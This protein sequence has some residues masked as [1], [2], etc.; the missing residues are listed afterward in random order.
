MAEPSLDAPP[1]AAW[2]ATFAAA[3]M[4][5]QQVVGKATRDTLYLSTYSVS[6]LPNMML[7]AAGCSFGAVLLM[8][9]ALARFSPAKVVPA[10]FILSL[11]LFAVEFACVKRFP[12]IVAVVL[13]IHMATLGSTVISGFWSLINERF[14]PHTAKKFVSRI[15]SGGTLGGVFGGLIAWRSASHVSL[16]GILFFL[17]II[18]LL[19]AVLVMVVQKPQ[20]TEVVATAQPNTPSQQLSAIQIL[21]DVRYLRTIA[22]LVAIGA[23]TETLI[24]YLLS[25]DVKANFPERSQM[26]TF[27]SMY[28]TGIGL[29]SFLL[30]SLLSRATLSFLGLAGTVAL[31]PFSVMLNGGV[32]LAVT[33]WWSMVLMRG[34]YAIVHNSLFRSGYELLFTPLPQDQKRPTKTLIDVGFDRAGNAL[35]SGIIMLLA[36]AMPTNQ[37]TALIG[38]AIAFAVLAISLTSNVHRG[39]VQALEE[40][41]RKG[42]VKLDPTAIHDAATRRTLVETTAALDRG[43]LLKEIELLREKQLQRKA[44]NEASQS[45]QPSGAADSTP[46]SN[47]VGTT[48]TSLDRDQLRTAL[49]EPSVAIQDIVVERFKLFRSGYSNLVIDEMLLETKLDRW[50]VTSVIHSLA[51][52]VVAKKAMRLLRSHI[53]QVTGQLIDTLLDIEV[54]VVIRRR[55]PRVLRASSTHR[56]TQGLLLGLKDPTYEVQY[57]TAIALGQIAAR[58]K[59]RKI[60]QQ[61]IYQAVIQIANDLT[62]G[63]SMD[64][65]VSSMIRLDEI[66]KEQRSPEEQALEL[67]FTC[68]CIILPREPLQI[69]YTALTSEHAVLKGTA[70]EYLENILPT[71]VRLAVTNVLG[72]IPERSKRDQRSHEV[73]LEEL[74]N[75]MRTVQ[76]TVPRVNLLPAEVEDE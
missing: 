3:L 22:I 16:Q 41:L 76:V 64:F 57:Q 74:V 72:E 36:W 8:G 43:Q 61:E 32:A 60:P 52:N 39:Y 19:C 71:D 13:Y 7:V 5:A 2:V 55:I 21:K 63:K 10:S 56:A 27:F 54:N 65:E 73:V 59:E 34:S 31:L 75:S 49:A 1:T 23:L 67:M 66:S 18:N 48:L 35:G 4:I 40:S 69:A 14:D 25:S 70:I 46:T 17:G 62:T 6:S 51:D 44:G 42:I 28:H 15:A 30:Q 38:L 9:R 58:E 11:S 20:K 37:R 45:T 50:L 53:D 68:L 24:D 12:G 33:R 29:V 26:L 47:T